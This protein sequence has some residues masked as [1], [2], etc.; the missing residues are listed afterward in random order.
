MSTRITRITH[1]RLRLTVVEDSV[2]TVEEYWLFPGKWFV[3]KL[4]I[5]SL[6]FWPLSIVFVISGN[7]VSVGK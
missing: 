6:T 7:R 4:H 5:V 1:T 2:A 3:F